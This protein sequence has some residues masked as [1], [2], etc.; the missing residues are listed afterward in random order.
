MLESF[1]NKRIKVFGS[2][3][4]DPTI[5]GLSK[6]SPWLHFGKTVIDLV[7]PVIS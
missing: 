1:I 3:R 4:N 7:L 6:I 2:K 5:D